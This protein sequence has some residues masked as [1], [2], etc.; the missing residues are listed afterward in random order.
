MA[1]AALGVDPWR[2]SGPVV[3]KAV[4]QVLS[5]HRRRAGRLVQQAEKRSNRAGAW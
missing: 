5:P 4:C 2:D 1:R 3:G